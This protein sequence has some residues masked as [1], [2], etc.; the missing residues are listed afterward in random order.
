[1]RIISRTPLRDFSQKH[2]QA[3]ALLDA[4]YAEVSHAHW[5]SFTD[6]KL[7]YQSKFRLVIKVAYKTGIVYIRFVGTHA[8]YTR[9]DA[10]TI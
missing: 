1:M 9:I 10:E 7:H 8:E 2:P 6:I 4:W 3:K 5:K